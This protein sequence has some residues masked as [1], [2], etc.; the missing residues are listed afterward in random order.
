M[1]AGSPVKRDVTGCIDFVDVVTNALKVHPMKVFG[2]EELAVR[3]VTTPMAL[4]CRRCRDPKSLPPNVVLPG[5][6]RLLFEEAT[7]EAWLADPTAFLPKAAGKKRGASSQ[8]C[9]C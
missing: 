5:D 9:R 4:Y 3:M 8:G 7:V 1:P 2:L 6:S